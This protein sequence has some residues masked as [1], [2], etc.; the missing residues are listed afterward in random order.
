ML[1]AIREYVHTF[2]SL[3]MKI[4]FGDRVLKSGAILT[5]M[6]LP[7][8]RR[9]QPI[10][11]GQNFFKTHVQLLKW[12][13]GKQQQH[14]ILYIGV[15]GEVRECGNGDQVLDLSN[16]SEGAQVSEGDPHPASAQRPLSGVGGL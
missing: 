5:L 11:I 9:T 14:L 7:A 16:L 12:L 2:V 6:E 15:R 13:H 10:T 8:L 4:I 1:S 3:S